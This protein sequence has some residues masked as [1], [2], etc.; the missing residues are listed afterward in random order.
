MAAMG[1]FSVLLALLA[2]VQFANG[3]SLEE[4]PFIVGG[5]PSDIALHPHHLALFDMV[6]GGPGNYM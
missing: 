4:D 3:T 5:I 1:K 2:I 6:R